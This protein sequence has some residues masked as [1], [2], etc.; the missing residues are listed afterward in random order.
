MSIYENIKGFFPNSLVDWD[1]KVSAVIFLGNCNFRCRYCHNRELVLEPEK[2]KAIS[3]E[4]IK[5][6]LERNRDFVDG[7]V[8]TGGEPTLY[9]D[10][11]DLLSEFKKMGLKI[12]LETN[13]SNP[14]MLKNLVDAGL[15]D[16][17]AMDIK[18]CFDKYKEIIGVDVDIEKIKESIHI[19]KSFPAYEFRITLFPEIKQEDFEEIFKYFKENNI[20]N[21]FLQQFRAE[22]CVDS[23]ADDVKPY[24]KE[25]IS[26]FLELAKKY[27]GRAGVRN[28]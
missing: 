12:K 22:N 24:S 2:I 5:N 15:V 14:E 23:K 6:Y 10:L 17:V 20:N 16:F 13:G 4:E 25:E 8:I 1:G 7:I 3:F 21:L 27:L 19:V 11:K 18:T 9:P 28:L 26:G